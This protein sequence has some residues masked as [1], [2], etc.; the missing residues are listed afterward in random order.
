MK[1]NRTSRLAGILYLV[2]IVTAGFAEGYVRGRLVVR[3]DGA[4]TA[5]NITSRELIYR[6]GG[7]ADAVN[8]V[9]DMGIALLFFELFKE[10]DRVLAGAAALFRAMGDVMGLMITF[11]HFVPIVLL[12]NA[13]YLAA[14]SRSEVEAQAL[15]VLRLHS[16]GYNIAM[17]L[18]GVHLIVLGC[19]VV[20]SRFWPAAIG[21]AVGVA[22]A[23]YVFNSFARL[24]SPPFAAHFSPY[25]LWPGIVAEFS[26]TVCLLIGPRIAVRTAEREVHAPASE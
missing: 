9:C 25:I 17:I 23:C 24:L 3:N 15:M 13:T 20:R 6:A 7:A 18:F 11:L 4:M 5:A 22:G 10:V 1:M 8:F 19:L 2:V 21:I 14:V 12:T 16:Q 26:V